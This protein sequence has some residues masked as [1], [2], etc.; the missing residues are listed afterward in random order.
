MRSSSWP[1]AVCRQQQQFFAQRRQ[2]WRTLLWRREELTRQRLKGQHP[3]RQRARA[4]L[5]MQTAQQRLMPP[6]HPVKKSYSS[7]VFQSSE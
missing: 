2:P 6:M 5:L 4:R 1:C 3:R 7:N